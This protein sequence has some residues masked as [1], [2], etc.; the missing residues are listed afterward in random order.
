MR[1]EHSWTRQIIRGDITQQHV[2]KTS[3]TL[4]T[5]R[6]LSFSCA[7]IL[8]NSQGDTMRGTGHRRGFPAPLL[9]GGAFLCPGGLPFLPL[10]P[11]T[12]S[13]SLCAALIRRVSFH[14][15]H[16]LVSTKISSLSP[17]LGRE[18][19]HTRADSPGFF[20]SAHIS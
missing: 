3:K 13:L 11:G 20:S 2:N 18:Q 5:T 7:V 4:P 9:T 8:K 6:F 12:H 19:T 17:R 14:L 1:S 16:W 15:I 10:L